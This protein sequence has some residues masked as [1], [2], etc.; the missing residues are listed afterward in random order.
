[1]GVL[2]IGAVSAL[3][4]NF[5]AWR[6][7]REYSLPKDS[8]VAELSPDGA[9]FTMGD[10]S[11]GTRSCKV[12]NVE[13]GEFF[14]IPRHLQTFVNAVNATFSSDSHFVLSELRAQERGEVELWKVSTKS[15][16]A[17]E[18]RGEKSDWAR[19]SPGGE[20]VLLQTKSRRVLL[21]NTETGACVAEHPGELS[22][23]NSIAVERYAVLREDESISIHSIHDGSEVQRLPPQ[24]DYDVRGIF[25]LS[26]KILM[27]LVYRRQDRNFE[28]AMSLKFELGRPD[29]PVLMNGIVVAT[30]PDESFTV[31]GNEEET[32]VVDLRTNQKIAKIPVRTENKVFNPVLMG[33]VMVLNDA[34]N[35]IAFDIQSGK[36]LYDIKDMIALAVVPYSKTLLCFDDR[37]Q[38]CIC[39]SVTGELLQAFGQFESISSENPKLL[40]ASGRT[41]LVFDGG[42][43]KVQLWTKQRP[44]YWWGFAWLPEFWLTVLLAI[45]CGWSIRRD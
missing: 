39:D 27:A 20:R 32:L 33:R 4:K 45:A 24:K 15:R 14:V 38:P 8:Y 34:G 35:S 1:M 30:T 11:S 43:S 21:L 36:R 25:Y 9:W 28:E 10:Y 42:N 23:Y 2:L 40:S 5:A 7:E 22:Y 3:W 6:V 13:T 41:L 44:E 12:W 18:L 37:R 31:V 26:N 19:F 16:V 17:L 29:A